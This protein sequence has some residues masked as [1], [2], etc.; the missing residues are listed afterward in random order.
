[1]HSL[2]S[3]DCLNEDLPDLSLFNISFHL[4][5]IAYFL[6]DVSVISQLH[7]YANR[8]TGTY[9]RLLE[10]SSKKASLY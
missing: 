9:Q 10:A 7:N 5:V 1:V 3:S 6:K 2:Q 4:L 8:L